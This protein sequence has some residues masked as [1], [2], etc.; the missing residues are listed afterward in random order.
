MSSPSFQSELDAENKVEAIDIAITAQDFT[1]AAD[2][3]EEFEGWNHHLALSYFHTL[4]LAD[5]T[6]LRVALDKKHD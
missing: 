5:Q 1:T 2:L 4:S 6:S 3:F